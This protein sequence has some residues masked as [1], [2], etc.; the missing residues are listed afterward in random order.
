[1]QT[2]QHTVTEPI[3]ASTEIGTHRLH[4]LQRTTWTW[5]LSGAGMSAQRLTFPDL[6][7]RADEDFGWAVNLPR[8]ANCARHAC[9]QDR[10]SPSEAWCLGSAGFALHESLACSDEDWHSGSLAPYDVERQRKGE[11]SEI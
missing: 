7:Q 6:W 3:N 9:R 11:Y 5:F 10:N 8:T 4:P 2:G 1:M